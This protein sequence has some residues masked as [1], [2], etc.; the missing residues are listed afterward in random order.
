MKGLISLFLYGLA[1]FLFLCLFGSITVMI[2]GIKTQEGTAIIFFFVV[3]LSYLCLIHRLNKQGEITA[4]KYREL[5]LA[6]TEKGWLAFFIRFYLY[7]YVYLVRNIDELKKESLNN[8][9]ALMNAA[10]AITLLVGYIMHFLEEPFKPISQTIFGW[11]ALI[12]FILL[13]LASYQ[14][15]KERIRRYA[16]KMKFWKKAF[17]IRMFH[18]S[19][20]RVM[21]RLLLKI[22][23]V[24]L[25][26][27]I[28][29]LILNS[30]LEPSY[31]AE[32]I[33]DLYFYL[34][35]AGA[36]IWAMV[37]FVSAMTV[38]CSIREKSLISYLIESGRTREE[39]Q[40]EANDAL[41]TQLTDNRT[42]WPYTNTFM[43]KDR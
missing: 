16:K 40:K 9:L 41:L 15:L 17:W 10:I 43:G 2:F 19:T 14:G 5:V 28:S 25:T 35:V 31:Q 22:G 42:L 13:A 20:Y 21:F 36:A 11:P 6:S 29:I 4:K 26:L 34:I 24:L 1:A 38:L 12:G 30:C 39:A 23:L 18:K 37:I 8:N 32:W 7:T 33:K 27:G 3:L